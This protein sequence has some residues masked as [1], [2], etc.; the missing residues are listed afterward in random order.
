VKVL[1]VGCGTGRSSFPL[2]KK[3]KNFTAID[4]SE[5]YIDYC[6]NKAKKLQENIKFECSDIADYRP[7]TNFDV[8]LLNW[9]GL[10]YQKDLNKAIQNIKSLMN[11]E[12]ILIIIDAY[13][14]TEYVEILQF[15]REEDLK[16]TLLKR[17]KVK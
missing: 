11:K 14:D 17:E 3:Y 16:P 4:I 13:Y 9:I 7:N 10:H 2:S 1:E 15:L 12:G 8:I 6:K 5:K